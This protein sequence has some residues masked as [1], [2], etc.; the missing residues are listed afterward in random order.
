MLAMTVTSQDI[1]SELVQ[2]CTHTEVREWLGASLPCV[3]SDTS[4]S[5]PMP[6]EKDEGKLQKAY[7]LS[8][9]CIYTLQF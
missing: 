1:K 4:S 9:S 5:M 8:I 6:L 7:H 2:V 3:I